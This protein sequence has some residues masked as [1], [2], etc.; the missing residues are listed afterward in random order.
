MTFQT[1]CVAPQ[2]LINDLDRSTGR[3]RDEV[4]LK[5][6]IM[7]FINAVLSQGAGEVTT[8]SSCLAVTSWSLESIR[9]CV[10]LTARPV[11]SSEF[12]CATSSSCWGS[13]RSSTSCACM[14]T[15]RWTGETRTEA[16]L[17]LPNEVV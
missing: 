9:L 2:T 17:C 16:W 12:T 4:N 5:T 13:S 7:S 15:P 8:A 6:A 11:W 3:Y 1:V 14:K 10:F